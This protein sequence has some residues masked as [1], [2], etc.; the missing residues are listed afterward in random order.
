MF[1]YFYFYLSESL[2]YFVKSLTTNFTYT[3]V[4][5]RIFKNN[6]LI[7]FDVWEMVFMPKSFKFFPMR[8]VVGFWGNILSFER[9]II[10]IRLVIFFWSI[11]LI[12]VAFDFAWSLKGSGYWSWE[13]EFLM[14]SNSSYK[15][16]GEEKL[17]KKPNEDPTFYFIIV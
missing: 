13:K 10:W 14:C 16:L 5:K 4:G 17:R 7:V 1:V 3:C 12:L 6:C 11:F 2:P 15:K 9:I 8:G